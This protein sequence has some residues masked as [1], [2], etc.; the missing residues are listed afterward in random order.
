[1]QGS[2]IPTLE[3]IPEYPITQGKQAG[4]L[5]KLY[6][7]EPLPWQQHV[8]DVWLAQDEYKHFISTRDGLQLP[9]QNGKN[10]VLEMFELYATVILGLKILHTAHEAKTCDVHWKRLLDFFD[11]AEDY[12]DLAAEVK[13]IRHTNGKESILLRNGASIEM[14]SRTKAA[15]RGFS[16]NIVICDEAQFLTDE[17]LDSIQSTIKAAAEGTSKIILTGTPPITPTDGIVFERI[18]KQAMSKAPRHSWIE[19]S[20]GSDALDKIDIADRMLWAR[21]NP[22]MGY[23]INEKTIEDEFA[24]A[25]RDGFARE[26]LSWWVD[27]EVRNTV[28]DAEEWAACA[29]DGAPSD[30]LISYGVK[31]SAD[32]SCGALAVCVKSDIPHVELVEVRDMNQGLTWFVDWLVSRANNALAIVI[33]GMSNAQPLV[34][35]L[36]AHG[37]NKKMIFKPRAGE[38][39]DAC[40][41]LLNAIHEKTVTHYKEQEQLNDAALSAEKRNIGSGGGW[42]FAGED[43][44]MVESIA[45]ALWGA[46]KSKRNPK[47]KQRIA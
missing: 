23:L 40:S 2:Q 47:R 36:L 9:R 24:T 19:W 25:S 16:C 27:Y 43:A 26:C 8:L 29:I 6:G 37:V 21:C 44:Y 20:C 14:S 7:R 15:L 34:D 3:C 4:K 13:K 22:S 18:R 31:F 30:G 35:A 12:P 33:D 46:K 41:M 10:A 38:V 42:G 1:M 39:A 11:N 28:I 32:G 45:L 17:Q 5:A